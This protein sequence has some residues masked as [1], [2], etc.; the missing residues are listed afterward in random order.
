MHVDVGRVIRAAHLSSGTSTVKYHAPTEALY[1]GLLLGVH[2]RRSRC[3]C[4][5]IYEFM[6]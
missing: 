2:Q 4:V 3:T 5:Y 1:T 6:N